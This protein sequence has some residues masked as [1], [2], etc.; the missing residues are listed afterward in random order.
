M[1]NQKYSGLLYWFYGMSSTQPAGINTAQAKGLSGFWLSS[2]LNK[3]HMKCSDPVIFTYFYTFY[4]DT[5]LS[6]SASIAWNFFFFYF[7]VTFSKNA[8]VFDFSPS[9][10][11]LHVCML[12]LLT[13]GLF[14]MWCI[15]WFVISLRYS[16]V[17][18]ETPSANGSSNNG[19]NSHLNCCSFEYV[20]KLNF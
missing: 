19:G 10:I 11:L 7:M 3:G 4:F 6:I 8:H 1:K 16:A 14:G 13:V 15:D 2:G 20:M 9:V 18:N 5:V 17:K 12:V